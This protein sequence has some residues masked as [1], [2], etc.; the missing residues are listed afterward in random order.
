MVL[1]KEAVGEITKL[2][3]R[4]IAALIVKSQND[5]EKVSEIVAEELCF[6]KNNAPIV[7]ND[8]TLDFRVHCFMGC[9]VREPNQ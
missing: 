7:Q 4:L 9:K 8:N 2:F 5:A 6:L 3:P 1:I